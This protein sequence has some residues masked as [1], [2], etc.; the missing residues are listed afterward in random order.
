MA[1]EV[2]V[3]AKGQ[4]TLRQSVL[5]HLGATP[6]RKLAVALLPGGRVELRPVSDMPKLRDLRAALF[7]PD[8]PV[9]TIEEM[10]AAIE[11]GARGR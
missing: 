9:V 1:I 4:V 5:A 8:Q 2:T 11:E 10:Q 6:G 7:R 3:T